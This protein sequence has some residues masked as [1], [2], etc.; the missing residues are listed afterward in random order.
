ML[1]KDP[2]QR[3]GC[4]GGGASDVKK[5]PFFRDINFKR[6]EAGIMEPPFVPDVSNEALLEGS[7]ADML[8]D[9]AQILLVNIEQLQTEPL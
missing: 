5:T 8:N 6:L 2:K 7:F 3:L 1:T 9:M 4:A